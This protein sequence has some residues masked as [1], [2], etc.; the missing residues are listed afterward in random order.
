MTIDT[1]YI[2]SDI[3]DLILQA[4][5]TVRN[6]LPLH[7]ALDVYQRALVAELEFLGLTVESDKKADIIYKNK[8]VGLLNI[9]LLVN[10]SVIVKL[11]SDET[12]S[13]QFVIEVKNQLHFTSYEVSLIL[14][15]APDGMHKRFV[16]TNDLKK[17]P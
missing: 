6:I 8:V 5:Y 13:E 7:L 10:N 4:F 9:E 15:F 11:I 3:S 12:I 1:K 17:K 16:Y 2:H 14:N